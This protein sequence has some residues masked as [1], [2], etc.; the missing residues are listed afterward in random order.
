VLTSHLSG[1]TTF[2]PSFQVKS[3]VFAYTGIPVHLGLIFGAKL[4]L[5][6]S[7]VKPKLMDLSTGLITAGDIERWESAEPSATTPS[8]K[9]SVSGWIRRVMRR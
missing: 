8:E 3:F 1:V 9:S 5:R 6:T 7:R 2:I 4:L